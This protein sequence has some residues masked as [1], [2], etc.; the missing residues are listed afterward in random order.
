MLSLFYEL[1]SM[2]VIGYY[3]ALADKIVDCNGVEMKDTQI[4]MI[5][6][7]KMYYQQGLTQTEI[8]KRLGISRPTISRLTQDALDQGIVR[9]EIANIPGDSS[10]FNACSAEK[11]R[12]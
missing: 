12:P 8:S 6:I 7:A 1:E 10:E 3:K 4:I 2:P 9:I 5:K 11:I